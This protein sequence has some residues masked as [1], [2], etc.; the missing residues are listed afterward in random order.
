MSDK[1]KN[2]YSKLPNGET[3]KPKPDKNFKQHYILS[4]SM[5]LAL[6]GTG[7]GKTNALISFLERKTNAF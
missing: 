2:Y 1:I 7:S 3:N 6:G 5:I 4:C